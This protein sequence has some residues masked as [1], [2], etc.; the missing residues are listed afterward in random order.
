[1]RG[2]STGYGAD[3][4]SNPEEAPE[5]HFEPDPGASPRPTV[6]PERDE[7]VG[8]D[9]QLEGVPD[10]EGMDAADAAERVD[11]DSVEQENRR[12]VPPTPENTLEA[13]TRDGA[14]DEITRP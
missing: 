2:F 9:T 7:P 1:M 12:D 10:E 8:E 11:E 3:M 14:E 4:S 6:P 5:V 13:R